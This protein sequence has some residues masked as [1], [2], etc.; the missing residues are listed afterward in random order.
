M[1]NLYWI[2]KAPAVA[3]VT[4]AQITAYDAGTTYSITIGGVVISTAGTGGS[5][6]T[7][8]TA[9]AALLNASTHPYFSAITWSANTDTIT[10][11]ADTAGVPFTFTSGA[12][13]GTGTF[14]AASTSTANSGPND[15]ST[16]AN[17]STGAVPA[18]SDHVRIEDSAVDILWGLS[19]SGVTL[20][21][22]NVG[23]SF[24]GKL[25]LPAGSF[26]ASATS[27]NTTVLEYR[28][29]Y[30]AISAGLVNIG[31]HYGAGNPG[32]ST[33]IKINTGTNATAITV[34]QS[35][36]QPAEANLKTVRLLGTHADNTLHVLGGSVSVASDIP[37]ETSQ[38]DE[39]TIAEGTGNV[40]IGAGVTLGTAAKRGGS[41]AIGCS[42]TNLHNDA[43]D[44]V[45]FG[46][47][48]FTTLRCRSGQV[49]HAGSG[50]VGTLQ[51]FGGT[52]RFNSE[53]VITS[54]T[55]AGGTLDFAADP[56][57][58]EVT[59]LAFTSGVLIGNGDIEFTDA[60]AFD[61]LV[62]TLT[63]KV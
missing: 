14:A 42:A 22:L 24:S 5:E 39:I 63:L 50:A 35:S 2:G 60:E 6:A 49:I 32:G 34:H 44:T 55:V 25:G 10:G 56:R 52:V 33:R 4:S 16:A 30:L 26:A 51:V 29:T 15:W 3:Q 17:W 28:T 37:F 21:S 31:Y 1:A 54:A 38:F 58:K 18:N 7:T 47:A 43:G 19:Q 20:A 48:A 40:L 27:V 61:D 57:H 41:L 8:A 59:A 36:A 46:T 45:T 13:G 53:G 11:T 9:L 62:G 12:S 23:L